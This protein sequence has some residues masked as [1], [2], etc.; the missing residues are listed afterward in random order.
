MMEAEYVALS[1]SC[2]DLFPIIDITKEICTVLEVH[3]H[4]ITNMHIKIYEDNAGALTLGCLEPR[5]MTPRSK[6]YAVKYHWFGTQIGP[7]NIDLVKIGTDDQIGDIFTKG[8]DWKKFRRL[9]KKL[10]GW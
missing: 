10:M 6:H 8:L 2:K 1:T 9:Q 4:D 3:L 7:R 5:R